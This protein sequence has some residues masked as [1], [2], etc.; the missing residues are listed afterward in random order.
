MRLLF[1]TNVFP[2]PLQ[3][4]KGIFNLSLARELTQTQQ[5][6]VIAPILWTDEWRLA[7]NGVQ[8][9][10]PERWESRHEIEIHYP[11]Y[12]Y[13]PKV[14]RRQY[15]WFFWHSVRRTVARVLAGFHPDAILAYWA[16][17]DGEAAVRIGRMLRVPVTVMV[18]GSD[19]LILTGHAARRRRVTNVLQAAD[20]IVTVGEDLRQNLID[21]EIDPD[22][23]HIVP[24]GIDDSL[25][26]PG[27]QA[28]A[29]RGLNLPAHKNILLWVGR[30]E[31]VKGLSVLLEACDRLR[32]RML[33]CHVYLIGDGSLRQ[34]LE[35]IC[36]TRQL[37]DRITFVG[38]ILHAALV[39]WYRAADYVVLPSLSEGV[40]NVLREALACGTPFVASRV[41]GIPGLDKGPPNR[42]VPPGDPAA[43]ADALL[44]ALASPRKPSGSLFH[45]P[46][47]ADS[48]ERL[49]H[50]LR[51]LVPRPAVGVS[52]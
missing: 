15:G 37:C 21:H 5:V 11:R 31:H 40:P 52:A 39:A 48:A 41:G 10:P 28:E 24:R 18:G 45:S 47:W 32:G 35:S 46:S 51:P 44:A 19:V 7:A 42:L 3:P 34:Q 4:T 9:M 13:P 26:N 23:I 43:L 6:R 25:F 30:M 8:A 38:P 33:D 49:M 2:N 1:I 29:R 12:Y 14:M 22:K 36:E 16:H 17:P 27:N 20:A 50:V